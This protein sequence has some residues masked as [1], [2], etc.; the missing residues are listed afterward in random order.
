MAVGAAIRAILVADGTLTGL[1]G[2]KVYPNTIPPKTDFPCVAYTV[3]DTE[4]T[5]TKEGASELDNIRMQIDV[6]TLNYDDTQTIANRIRTLLDQYSGTS[7]SENIDLCFFQ[8]QQEGDY[9]ADLGVFWLSQTYEIQ[10]K[11]W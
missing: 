8:G 10:L 3:L 11:R 5:D 1:I 6:Y 9:Q 7:A 2:A 4:P